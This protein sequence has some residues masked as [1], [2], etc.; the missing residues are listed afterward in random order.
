METIQNNC[1]HYNNINATDF[2]T[3][4]GGIPNGV[5]VGSNNTT[6]YL[7]QIPITSLTNKTLYTNSTNHICYCS[8]DMSV[9]YDIVRIAFTSGIHVNDQF[10]VFNPLVNTIRFTG[11][12]TLQPNEKLYWSTAHYNAEGNG[13]ANTDECDNP[14][15][16]SGIVTVITF[17]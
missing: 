10:A 4:K 1:F 7:Q 2:I 3:A 17:K 16:I 9:T 11:L 5:I 12:F 14:I 6:V 8:V 13:D 15:S